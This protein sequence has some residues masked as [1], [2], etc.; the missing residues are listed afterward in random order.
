M[1]TSTGVK[2][3]LVPFSE[4]LERY[5]LPRH[6]SCAMGRILDLVQNEDKE[7]IE[8]ALANRQISGTV[9]SKALKTE[10]Y[11]ISAFSVRRHRRGEC[12]C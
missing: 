11:S 5:T 12:A 7:A 3:G 6:N 1:I 9:L 4:N 10:G 2:G 8:K